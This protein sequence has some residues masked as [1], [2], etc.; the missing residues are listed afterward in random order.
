[1]RPLRMP[2]VFLA[3]VSEDT[4]V[5]GDEVRGIIEH[6][7]LVGACMPLDDSSRDQADLELLCE[8]LVAG[9]ICC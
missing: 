7:A 3:I 9:Q 6:V 4:A 5:V 2:D 8:S 1:M